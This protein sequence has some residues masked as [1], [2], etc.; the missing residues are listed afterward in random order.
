[1]GVTYDPLRGELFRAEKGKGAYLNDSPIHVSE[2]AL[3]Q[4]S[5]LS[6]DPGYNA[7]QGK[8]LLNIVTRL[9]P[10]VHSL[11]S[12]GSSSVA[13]AYVACGRVDLYVRSDLH[14][15]DIASGILLVK[16]AGGKV[17]DWQGKPANLQNKEI[18]AANN[19]LH[20]EFL[21]QLK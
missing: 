5:L 8:K 1:M 16:E 3:L 12:M 17:S 13:L 11:R 19:K 18:I 6:F 9:W 4:T 2:R 14:P 15:W 10:K 7:I 21:S 20:Q